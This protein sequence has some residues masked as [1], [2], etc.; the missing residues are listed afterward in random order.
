[1][2][3]KLEEESLSDKISRVIK[4]SIALVQGGVINLDSIPSFAFSQTKKELNTLGYTYEEGYFHTGSKFCSL[5]N[6]KK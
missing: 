1:M 3:T 4:E 2:D 5:E 6:I